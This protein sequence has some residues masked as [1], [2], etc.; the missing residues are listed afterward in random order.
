MDGKA[1]QTSAT[2]PNPPRRPPSPVA[3]GDWLLRLLPREYFSCPRRRSVQFFRGAPRGQ[4]PPNR[5]K[6]AAMARS[7]TVAALACALLL[8]GCFMQGEPAGPGTLRCGRSSACSHQA[9]GWEQRRHV[10]GP[11][12]RAL[13]VTAP[14]VEGWGGPAAWRGPAARLLPRSPS[15]V[16]RAARQLHHVAPPAAQQGAPCRAC[17]ALVRCRASWAPTD[18]PAPPPPRPPRLPCRA[19][20]SAAVITPTPLRPFEGPRVTT[21]SPWGV[22]SSTTQLTPLS[23]RRAGGDA[24]LS[25]MTEGPPGPLSC[26]RHPNGSSPTLCCMPSGSEGPGRRARMGPDALWTA[27]QCLHPHRAPHRAPAPPLPPS[28][29]RPLRRPGDHHQLRPRDPPE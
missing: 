16:A 19:G 4:H 24:M 5:P 10:C 29:R 2:Y 17:N 18:A 28:C 21:A 26:Y 8:A 27:P 3:A 22:S 23:A 14:R 12:R 9:G 7:A 20:A 15:F 25:N 1:L 13:G 11:H 6:P